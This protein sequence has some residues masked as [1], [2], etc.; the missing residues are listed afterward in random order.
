MS[1]RTGFL[2]AQNRIEGILIAVISFTLALLSLFVL[3]WLLNFLPGV[4]Y[5]FS[6][7]LEAGFLNVIWK[8]GPFVVD[9]EIFSITIPVLNF[10]QFLNF[11]FNKIFNVI[12]FSSPLV[13]TGLAVAIAFRAGLFN[14]G[15]TGQMI[16]GGAFAGIW[17]AA[18]APSFLHN[19]IIYKVLCEGL[20]QSFFV[21]F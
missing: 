5:N 7:I 20:E 21:V 19:P 16:M 15:G 3:L 12:H 10:D 13:L 18:L 1:L 14:I 4:N 6:E 8:K 9:W 11:N 2:Q 17:A